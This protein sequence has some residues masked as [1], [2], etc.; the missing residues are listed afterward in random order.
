MTVPNTICYLDAFSGVSG[1]MLV[2]A[3]V[4][5]GADI[6]ELLSGLDSLGAEAKLQFEQV[7][8]CGIAATRFHVDATRSRAHRHLPQI[9]KMIDGAALPGKVRKNAAAV[10]QRLGEAEAAVH[11]VPLEKVHFHEVGAVDSIMDIVGACLGFELLGAD[12]IV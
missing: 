6:P 9:L 2:G 1:D 4:D 7:T 12:A 5:A 3:L 11:R 8:R 10:F